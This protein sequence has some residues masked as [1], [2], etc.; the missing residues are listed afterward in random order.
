[1]VYFN[2]IKLLMKYEVTT[3][4]VTKRIK[5]ISMSLPNQ[6][7]L[8]PYNE[9]DKLFHRF[10]QILHIQATILIDFVLQQY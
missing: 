10:S 2:Q 3:D 9:K 6:K 1:M 4:T 8:F 7:T 5:R